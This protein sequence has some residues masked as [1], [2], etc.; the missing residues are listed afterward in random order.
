MV[1]KFFLILDFSIFSSI[2]SS[3][4]WGFFIICSVL[5]FLTQSFFLFSLKM[6]C[7]YHSL[8]APE[9]EQQKILFKRRRVS[10]KSF[11]V[12]FYCCFI[13]LL[14]VNSFSLALAGFFFTV[15]QKQLWQ[16]GNNQMTFL[17]IFWAKFDRRYQQKHH[18]IFVG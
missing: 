6:L 15:Y 8:M 10:K 9:W 18:Q 3:L 14:S 5:N 16:Y 11:L 12:F 17:L 13:D 4:I 7:I 1:D 2:F